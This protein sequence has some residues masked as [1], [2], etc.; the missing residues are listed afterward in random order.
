MSLRSRSVDAVTLQEPNI[1]FMQ[2]DVRQKY[3]DIFKEHFGQA[4]V[5]TA[6]SCIAAPKLWKLGGVV[7]VVLGSWAQ[8]ITKVSCDDL[9]RW[10]SATMTGSDGNSVTI[11]SF[12]NVVD[13]KLQHAGPST[14]FA[15]QYR[16]LKLA[17]VTHPNPRQ[18]CVD[19]LQREVAKCV[20]NK[21]AIVII[22]DFNEALGRDAGLM[23]SVCSNNGLF[24]VHALVHG[25]QADIP[26][27]TCGSK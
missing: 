23:A 11:F 21:E 19:D 13:V 14:V 7:L 12:Y 5:L 8:H 9:G 17:G 1:D 18:Q 3:N 6:T 22:G 10:V 20:V 2:A 25:G 15:Q 4:R 27:Y 16:L 26:T 24:D